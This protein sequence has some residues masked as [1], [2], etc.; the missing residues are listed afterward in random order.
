[1]SGQRERKNDI[2]LWIDPHTVRLDFHSLG[3]SII[4]ATG[5]MNLPCLWSRIKFWIGFKPLYGI[6][7]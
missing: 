1:M 5:L 2:G 7:L 4:L 3:C 6:M